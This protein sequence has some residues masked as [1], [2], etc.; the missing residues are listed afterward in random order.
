[1]RRLTGPRI[2]SSQHD[3][4]QSRNVLAGAHPTTVAVLAPPPENLVRV[5]ASS[6]CHLR[7]ASPRSE[8]QLHDPPL[9]CYRTAHPNPPLTPWRQQLFHH[10]IVISTQL[11]CPEGMTRRLPSKLIPAG[12]SLPAP[13]SLAAFLS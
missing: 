11:S 7:H 12:I 2:T 10:A 8:R 4:K 1:L 3:R 9:L 5:H 6:L 13:N